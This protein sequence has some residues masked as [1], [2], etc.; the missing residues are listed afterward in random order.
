MANREQYEAF[1][2]DLASII[3]GD[4]QALARHADAIADSDEARDLRHDADRIA[5]ELYVAG[6]DYVAPH[7]DHLVAKLLAAADQMPAPQAAPQTS[8]VQHVAAAAEPAPSSKHTTAAG[9]AFQAVAAVQPVAAHVAPAQ[10][11]A[12]EP[13]VN[14][15]A[16]TQLTPSQ[17]MPV[18]PVQ[19]TPAPV[20]VVQA[21]PA[22]AAQ[23]LAAHAPVARPTEPMP[24]SQQFTQPTP[25]GYVPAPAVKVRDRARLEPSGSMGRTPTPAPQA[26]PSEGAKVI[27]PKR[28]ALIGAG[29][30]A[31]LAAAA[32]GI[33][34][35]SSG[36]STGTEDQPVAAG[37][38][39]PGSTPRAW[40]GRIEQVSRAA[41]GGAS[42]IEVQAPGASGFTPATAGTI[43]AAGSVIRTDARTRA[44]LAFTDGT[45]VTL[46]HSTEMRLNQASARHA[47][48]ERGALVADVRPMAEVGA[49]AVFDVPRG[50]VTVLGTR[51]S[52]TVGQDQTSVQ[53]VHGH[54]RIADGAG[55]T[56]D[57]KTGQEGT[58]QSR[59]GV[60][61]GQATGMADSTDW[62]EMTAS[63]DGSPEVAVHG[64]GEL[65]ARRPGAQRDS[66]QALR[67]AN[68]RV[69]VRIQGN[70]ARTEIEEEFANDTN[71]QLEGTYRFPLP[72]N[73]QIARLALW[74]DDRLEEGAFVD[75]DRAANI[76][77]GVIRNATPRAQQQQREEFVWVPGP[78]EDPALLEWQ[79]GGRF[80]LRIFPIPAR[81]SRKVILAYTQ[82]IEP[83]SNGTRRYV[84]PLP[85]DPG[86]TTRAG[87]FA[88]DLRVQGH[89]TTTGVR[90]HNYTFQQSAQNDTATL[91]LQQTNFVPS[92][93]LVVEYALPNRNAELRS[94]TFQ[95]AVTAPTAATGA[96][97]ASMPAGTSSPRAPS[98]PDAMMRQAAFDAARA[99]DQSAPGFV[100]LAIRPEL[101]P[102]SSPQPRDYA[103][104]VDSSHSM[105]GERY[106][107]AVVLVEQM[108][109]LMD[110]RDRFV[111]VA[112]DLT[113]RRQDGGLR[114][115]SEATA[116]E[117][118][119]FLESI[120][121]GNA[122]DVL[123]SVRGGAA[124]LA[125][126]TAPD[127][128]LR[129]MMISDGHATA[130]YREQSRIGAAATESLPRGATL[131]TVG[132]GG[133]ADAAILR[134]L[135]RSGGGRFVPYV[136]G[137]RSSGAAL[138][139]LEST[140]GT[141]LRDARVELPAGLTQVAPATLPTVRNGEEI[142]V[143]ARSNGDVTGEVRL[144]GKVGDQDWNDRYPVQLRMTSS[145]GNAFVPR[146]WAAS[147]IDDL[148]AQDSVANRQQISYLS[149]RYGVLSRYTSLLV[150]E[151]A[152][153][154]RAFRVQRN[155]ALVADWTGNTAATTSESSGLET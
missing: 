35:L 8:G 5:R 34:A 127:R 16:A 112:C 97:G 25:V 140:Y 38:G 48:V 30:I 76:W 94:W 40:G 51:L 65:R 131:T 111:V 109:R 145:E 151:S 117:S 20:A 126:Q 144:T 84:Y 43:V 21:A 105:R 91:A 89:D 110:R 27:R 77:R 79:R 90:A 133:D 44:R 19:V 115:P 75:R 37:T 149:E 50:R 18:V 134:T 41:A 9:N 125:G 1:C 122:S 31:A 88:V 121:P 12:P 113:C 143:V 92:G 29:V 13:P 81:G 55:Q 73:A 78:W 69:T 108:V 82:V 128:D 15:F 3:E 63:R 123:A 59:G 64:L 28:W 67:L 101:P 103:F 142:L 153:M 53:V 129:I 118:R 62:A 104:V 70:V 24:T 66:E 136:P 33:V 119:R 14:A 10:P 107:R 152:A 58:I 114:S 135:A 7:P 42:G 68:H 32:A 130:G 138:A 83:Q 146:L 154:F 141:V 85:H 86:G 124:A 102:W 96:T 116:T 147:R 11:R 6:A 87:N 150:L 17:P 155:D 71:E 49:P 22:P 61:V 95:P 100:L 36:G 120:E 106:A 52:V 54:A 74:V 57:V 93:D 80:D 148:D 139:A 60:S 47:V 98:D 72:P 23:A 46:G 45:S 56:A 137:Q 4:P 39:E 99:A 2:Q 26:Q 132:I